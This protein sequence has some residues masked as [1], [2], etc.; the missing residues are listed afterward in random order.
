MAV[1]HIRLRL[2]ICYPQHT[3]KKSIAIQLKAVCCQV[4]AYGLQYNNGDLNKVSVSEASYMAFH[5]G[6]INKRNQNENSW[7]GT[8]NK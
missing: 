8:R 3:D 1:Y 4:L 2:P 7:E 5:K 6:L